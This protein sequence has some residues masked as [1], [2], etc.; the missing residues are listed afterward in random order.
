MEVSWQSDPVPCKG[1]PVPNQLLTDVDFIPS[2]QEH[3][4]L[5]LHVRDVFREVGEAEVLDARVALQ[6]EILEVNSASN[7]L[8]LL[9]AF[10][11]LENLVEFRRQRS[12][13]G[14]D[15]D[16]RSQAVWLRRTGG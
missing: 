7:V 15:N 14:A 6:L 11:L 9:A 2:I 12:G 4:L 13:G 1:D 5:L 8:H 3:T 16:T 10:L